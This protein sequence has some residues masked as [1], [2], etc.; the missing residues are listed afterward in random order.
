[1]NFGF[2]LAILTGTLSVG[3]R[4][5][6]LVTVPCAF[7]PAFFE[8]GSTRLAGNSASFV[9]DGY[10]AHFQA[11]RSD[12]HVHITL[13]GVA[14]DGGSEI[15]N[16]RL[17]RRRAEQVRRLLVGWGVGRNRIRIVSSDPDLE[18]W[19]LASTEG[20]AVIMDVRMPRHDL[21][22]LMPRDGPVC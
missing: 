1:M 12:S 17:A 14:T 13:F 20:R 6:G 18:N 21:D 11:F 10:L 5:D 22:R 16:R 15:L 19:P 7:L 8:D 9:R 2:F 3:H 4:D